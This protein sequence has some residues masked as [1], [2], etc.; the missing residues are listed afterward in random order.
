MAA[1][2]GDSP[3]ENYAVWCTKKAT[4]LAIPYK[5]LWAR[6]YFNN[7]S[8]E[9][10]RDSRTGKKYPLKSVL[11]LPMDETYWMTGIPGEW[12]AQIFEFP[13]LSPECTHIDIIRL[14]GTTGLSGAKDDYNLSVSALQANQHKMKYRPTVVVE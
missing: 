13:A 12:F 7:Q 11:G 6:R 5:M 3:A 9:Y 2:T 1:P 10:L 8:C 4:Y 14:Q